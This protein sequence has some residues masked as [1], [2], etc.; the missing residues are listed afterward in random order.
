MADT[1]RLVGFQ[2]HN[3][4]HH[5]NDRTGLVLDLVQGASRRP[6][7]FLHVNSDQ[8]VNPQG[9]YFLSETVVSKRRHVHRAIVNKA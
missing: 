8:E 6:R 2:N 9:S 7:L 1:R 3:A 5:V 4:C